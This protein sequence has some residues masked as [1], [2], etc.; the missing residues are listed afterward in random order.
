MGLLL[1]IQT[2]VVI[3]TFENRTSSYTLHDQTSAS[4]YIITKNFNPL[5]I[6]YFAGF[7]YRIS[8]PQAVW[9]NGRH[10]R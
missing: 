3:V 8:R 7:S 6:G 9:A 10:I 4:G 2:K 1:S 5:H